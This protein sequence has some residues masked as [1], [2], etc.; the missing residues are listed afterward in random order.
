MKTHI[1]DQGP[2]KVRR[3][4]RSEDDGYQSKEAAGYQ[5]SS[6][7]NSM[8]ETITVYPAAEENGQMTQTIAIPVTDN[9]MNYVP[10]DIP[11]FSVIDVQNNDKYYR[12]RLLPLD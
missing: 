12:E 4:T 8:L 9:R 10:A 6:E 2:K 1:L 5:S 11:H 7:P 3:K